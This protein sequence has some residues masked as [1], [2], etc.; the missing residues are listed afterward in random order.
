MIFNIEN[1]FA[2]QLRRLSTVQVFTVKYAIANI[3]HGNLFL[4]VDGNPVTYRVFND[5]E[6]ALKV[7]IDMYKNNI[8]FCINNGGGLYFA[9]GDLYVDYANRNGSIGYSQSNKWI[10]E[11]AQKYYKDEYNIDLLM[12]K[13]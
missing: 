9:N 8:P 2:D 12:G 4:F 10:E 3:S 11:Q 13:I 1:Y 5:K 6:F 7:V